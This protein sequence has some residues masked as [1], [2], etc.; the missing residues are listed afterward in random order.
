MRCLK[1]VT[2]TNAREKE[3]ENGTLT[4]ENCESLETGNK[5]FSQ[6]E[7]EITVESENEFTD[8]TQWRLSN[9]M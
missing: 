8:V 5:I 1:I 9:N 2:Q 6:I 3:E 4:I 7:I